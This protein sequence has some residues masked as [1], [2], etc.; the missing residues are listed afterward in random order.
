MTADMSNIITIADHAWYDWIKFYDPVDKQF[1]EEKMYLGNY[2][3]PAIDVDPSLTVKIM[4]SNGEVVHSSTYRSL[5]HE[6]VHDEK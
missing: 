3:K 2:L 5:L 6:E 4:K 1:P